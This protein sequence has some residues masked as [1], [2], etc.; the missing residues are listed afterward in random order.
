MMGLRPVFLFFPLPL[1]LEDEAP[2]TCFAFWMAAFLMSLPVPFMMGRAGYVR[3]LHA[4][5]GRTWAVKGEGGRIEERHD[6]TLGRMC[7]GGVGVGGG[8]EGLSGEV[9]RGR[10]VECRGSR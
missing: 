2:A 3:I 6:L 8:V 9:R 10:V 4:C 1:P 7:E 5:P